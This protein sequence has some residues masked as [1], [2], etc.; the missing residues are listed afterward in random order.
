[1]TSSRHATGRRAAPVVVNGIEYRAR[2]GRHPVHSAAVTPGPN[3]L[4]I[5]LL[6]LLLVVIV[7]AVAVAFTQLMPLEPLP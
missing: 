3:R 4:P 2:P 5:L 7:V 6:A 1:M